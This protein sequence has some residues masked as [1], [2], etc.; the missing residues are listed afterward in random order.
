MTELP[1]P[2]EPYKM[3]WIVPA[4][5]GGLGFIHLSQFH[6]KLWKRKPD[7]NGLDVWVLIR[8]IEFEELRPTCIGH[9]LALVGFAEASNAVLV[10][11]DSGVFMVY[12]QSTGFKKLSNL[13][14]FCLHYPF[15][16][17]YPAGTG[18]GDGHGGDEVLNNI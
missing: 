5:D 16:Y 10:Q 11:T 2:V 9:P 3:L 7:S 6:A 18:T 17:F 1:A 15:E 12:L 13:S 4:E 14:V 8:A